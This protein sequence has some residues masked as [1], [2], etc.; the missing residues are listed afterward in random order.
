[1][2]ISREECRALAKECLRHA[3]NDR[4]TMELRE[5]WLS[6]AE[7]WETW[8]TEEQGRVGRCDSHPTIGPSGSV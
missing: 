2:P 3:A 4:M 6:L 5:S 1:M 7:L 8:E